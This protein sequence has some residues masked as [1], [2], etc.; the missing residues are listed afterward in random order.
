[1]ANA[2]VKLAPSCFTTCQ[3]S[4]H[5]SIYKIYISLSLH[6]GV[7]EKHFLIIKIWFLRDGFRFYPGLLHY[8]DLIMLAFSLCYMESEYDWK[9]SLVLHP[10]QDD[11]FI[12]IS[13]STVEGFLHMPLTSVEQWFRGNIQGH[14]L[15]GNNDEVSLWLSNRMWREICSRI[16]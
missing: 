11:H 2:T 3:I 5:I 15:V 14:P 7:S 4:I 13:S 16:Q 8:R 10:V 9:P 6:V 12:W 1:M